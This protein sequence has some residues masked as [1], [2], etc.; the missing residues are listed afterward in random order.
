MPPAGGVSTA[1]VCRNDLSFG[2]QPPSQ[3]S[4]GWRRARR[5]RSSQAD[6][7]QRPGCHGVIARANATYGETGDSCRSGD[8]WGLGT[9]FAVGTSEP[10][11]LG[12]SFWPP[13]FAACHWSSWDVARPVSRVQRRP[14]SLPLSPHS[15]RRETPKWARRPGR[16][17]VSNSPT[18]RSART[19]AGRSGGRR[20]WCLWRWR[21]SAHRIAGAV[22]ILEASTAPVS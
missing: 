17:A 8:R 21:W 10:C 2:V 12:Q 22:P 19:S 1:D 16:H 18:A 5:I 20:G 7:P 4:P 14:S 13:G 3:R 11:R 15:P 6:T 9:V